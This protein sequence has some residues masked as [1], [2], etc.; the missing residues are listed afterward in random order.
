MSEPKNI[1]A[2]CPVCG[3]GLTFFPWEDDC[4]S[5][6][7]CSSC[8]IQFGLEDIKAKS[9]DE[10]VSIYEAYRREWFKN[11]AKWFSSKPKPKGWSADEQLKA[12]LESN[13]KVLH[14]C[15]E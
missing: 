5:D 12:Y 3:Y 13:N 1:K 4:P 8:G 14:I 7:I 10:F 11:G 6:E 15:R 9:E 2:H